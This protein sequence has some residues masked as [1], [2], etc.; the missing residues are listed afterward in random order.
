MNPCISFLLIICAISTAA[1]SETANPGESLH[2]YLTLDASTGMA[3]IYV[4]NVGPDAVLV[5]LKTLGQFATGVLLVPLTDGKPGSPLVPIEIGLQNP[6]SYRTGRKYRQAVDRTVDL[7]YGEGICISFPVL[8][9][10]WF[11]SVEKVLA[12]DSAVQV[13][14]NTYVVLPATDSTA[15]TTMTIAWDSPKSHGITI[16]LAL[17][18]KLKALPGPKPAVIVPNK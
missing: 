13:R 11:R 2:T 16:D 8:E 9:S 17:L 12:K 1:S 6:F 3:C 4:Q 18:A 5:S 7:D 15:E 14:P 10:G